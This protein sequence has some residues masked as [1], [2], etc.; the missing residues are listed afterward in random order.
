MYYMR[1]D[2]NGEVGRSAISSCTTFLH[3]TVLIDDTTVV[4]TVSAMYYSDG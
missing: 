3:G 4:P 2:M 1:S